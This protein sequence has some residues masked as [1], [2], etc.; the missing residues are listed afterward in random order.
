MVSVRL[1]EILFKDC[2]VVELFKRILYSCVEKN[3]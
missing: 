1:I 3:V 2:N